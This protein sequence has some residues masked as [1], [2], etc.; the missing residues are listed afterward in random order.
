M[1]MTMDGFKEEYENYKIAKIVFKIEKIMYTK[2]YQIASGFN[3]I[4]SNLDK[5]KELF[6]TMIGITN[7]IYMPY[8]AK[9][10]LC[11][12]HNGQSPDLMKIYESCYV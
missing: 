8:L 7:Y 10:R 5:G 11:K 9:S 12:V 6:F 2:F 1:S 4:L 3:S